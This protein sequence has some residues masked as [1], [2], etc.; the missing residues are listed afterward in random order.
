[1]PARTRTLNTATFVVLGDGLTAGAGDFGI[2]EELQ[3]FSFPAQVARRLNT[4]FPQ[5][6]ME[7][8][9]IGP[10][11]GFP[12]LP[13]RLPQ[14]MQ[15]TVLKE[16]PPAGLYSN[17]SIPGLKLVDAL[18]RRPAS[19][20]I[21]RS[22]GLQT[23][24][25]LILG[26]PGLLMPGDAQLPTAAEYALF[27]RPTLTLIAL[28]YHD[29]IDAA[30]KGDPSWVPDDVS[31][32]MNYGNVLMPFARVPGM[33]IACTIPDPVDTALFT[34]VAA[35]ARVVK[36]DP[37]VLAMLCGLNELDYL[38]PTGL[39]EAGC[40]L[41]T[42]TPGSL[43]EGSVVTASVVARLS[44]RTSSLNRQI[45]ALAEEQGAQILDL[46]RLFAR[47]KRDGVTVGERHLTADYMG[48]L[49]SL[50]GVYPGATGHGVIANE[51][52]DVLNTAEQ[53]SHAPI[54]LEA[55]MA[56]DPVAQY[57][58]AP[59]ALLTVEDLLT[60]PAVAARKDAALE[61]VVRAPRS[62][63]APGTR[64]T[65][66]ASLE[67]TVMLDQESSFFGDALRAAHAT[68]ERDIPF[69]SSPNTFFGGLCLTQSHLSGSVT[70]RFTA[71][72]GD[73]AHFTLSVGS[74][75]IGQDGMLTAPQFFKLPSILNKVTDV[76]GITSAGDV[77]LATGEVTNL[78][79]VLGFMN[80]A[81]I[82]L[83]S[84]NPNIPPTPIE[85]SNESRQDPKNSH[86]GSAWAK[87]EQRADGTLDFMMNGVSFMPLGAGFGGEPLRFPLPFTGPAMQFASI[88]AV[89]SALHPHISLSTTAVDAVACP[90]ERIPD[91]P[92]NTVREYTTFTHNTA[93]GDKFTLNIPEME[94][95]ATGRSHL[96]GRLLV[97]FGARSGNSV[98]VAVSTLMP[99]GMFA[100]PPDSPLA[101]EFPGRLT[102]GLL[103]HDETLRFK[104][105]Q[106]DMKGVAWVDDPFEVSLG[107]IDLKT[108]KV[109]GGFL[110]RGF[111][112]Q[113]V[114]LTLL[115][116]EPR[117][118]KS[119]WYM[120]GPAAFHKDPSGQTVFGYSGSV[121]VD[122]PEGFG[123]PRPDLKS[124]YKVGPNSALDPYIYI[125]AMDGIAPPPAG[126][127]GGARGVVASNG[128]IFSYSYAIPGYPSGR[129]TAFEYI[130]ET[131]GGTFRMGSLVWVNFGNANR[132]ALPGDVDCVTFSGIGLWS[133][134][135][136]GPHM[137]TVQI[138]TAPELSYVSIMI[139]GGMTS[140]VNT[141]PATAVLPFADVV[142]A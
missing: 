138:S 66:P 43:P 25:N 130:N 142:L 99:G 3:P 108:G 2:S 119:S 22:D 83:V 26:L 116:L 135:M 74:G 75:L 20:L 127:T 35:A 12:D 133:H 34:P 78:K 84:V 40:R 77:N 118:P 103:G 126:K 50:N 86:Y 24:I 137:C 81:L 94:G 124:V 38:T 134:D 55:L 37:A 131:T 53:T 88:P 21:H 47:V 57:R 18:T 90:A 100:K 125:Q 9:G 89:G 58:L 61:H 7:A 73:L 93:F 107:S 5:P 101:K 87:F 64:I 92:L 91:I 102:V 19:P 36:A 129:P 72:K 67:A 27:R 28:G 52:L 39:V 132:D 65:L 136:S 46:H 16:F 69:G 110:F 98:P 51:L 140:N 8:P 42:R 10:V 49:F 41:I 15:T 114:L 48:G 79:I 14:P 111:I 71:P 109:I 115:K 62:P 13:V 117:T 44:E 141:K 128:Q 80:S 123:F 76:E 23:A 121:R 33:V 30:L 70:F 1:M 17:V 56:A 60:V 97:Q 139:D 113:D 105:I 104:K 29:I 11:I 120:R 63:Q 6:L 106:Y 4:P 59:G 95:G 54:K 45:R 82:A 96:M 32:R 31:F 68:I 122:Y 85:F 112:I